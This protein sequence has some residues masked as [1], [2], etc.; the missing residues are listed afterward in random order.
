MTLC[1]SPLGGRDLWWLDKTLA[2]TRPDFACA[3]LVYEGTYTRIWRH[4]DRDALLSK[5]SQVKTM[6]RDNLRKYAA[7]QAW[8]EMTANRTLQ[9][10]GL[11]TADLLG[12]GIPVA[13]WTRRES[14]LFMRELAPHDT[15][16][17]VLRAVTDRQA[18]T[19][20]L[21]HVASDVATIYRNGYHH[22]D[23]HLENVLRL[24]D[25]DTPRD[26]VHGAKPLI[27]IDND[28]RYSTDV[29]RAR[30][31][32]AGSLQ[33]LVDTSTNFISRLEWW[34]FAGTLMRRL[35]RTELGQ[36]LAATTVADF[37]AAFA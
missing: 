6:P 28:L 33:Q 34:E 4:P 1:R 23:C 29:G 12:Y 30:R 19:A 32:L 16:R 24:R 5:V 37:R 25:G 7:C 31:R 11:R 36:E 2:A 8:R 22:K 10:L 3:E 20:L 35:C 14:I 27:W 18:R 21:D 9:R 17:V 15:L 26:L 13:P